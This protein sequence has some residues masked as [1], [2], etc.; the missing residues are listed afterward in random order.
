VSLFF[1]IVLA[2]KNKLCGLDCFI[3][4]RNFF[5]LDENV[6]FN[7]RQFLWERESFSSQT[8]WM[9]VPENEIEKLYFF[10]WQNFC[11]EVLKTKQLCSKLIHL[12]CDLLNN[13]I[14]TISFCFC[15]HSHLKKE[16]VLNKSRDYVELFRKVNKIICTY[17]TFKNVKIQVWISAMSFFPR[18]LEF[19]SK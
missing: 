13:R 19:S 6:L 2:G 4:W 8:V 16:K 1:V 12:S 10:S 5:C 14:V 11:L 9:N 17:V 15:K 18:S 7:D 3:F